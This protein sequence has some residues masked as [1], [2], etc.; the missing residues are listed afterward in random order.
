MKLKAVII[1][2][3]GLCSTLNAQS[4]KEN[5]LNSIITSFANSIKKDIEEDNT[6]GSISIAIV[7]G[8]SIIWSGAYGYADYNNNLKAD[9]ASI[10]RTGSISKSFTAF[11]MMQL[12]EDGTIKL[13]DPIEK[14]LP[15]ISELNGYSDATKITFKHL[16]SH[17]SGLI[18]EPKLKNAASGTIEEWESKVLQSIPKTSFKYKLREQYSYSNIG[19]AILGLA[20]SRAAKKSFITLVKEKIFNP[21]HMTNSFFIVPK[22]RITHLAKGMDTSSAGKNNSKAELEHKG[23]GYKVPNGGIYATPNDLAKFAAANMGYTTLLSKHSLDTMQSKHTPEENYG[24]G[25]FLYQDSNVSTVGHGG[26]VAGYTCCLFF[27]KESQYG[28]I[29]MRNYN[30]GNTKLISASK[31]LIRKLKSPSKN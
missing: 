14:Y 16:A 4:K 23:R 22:D 19:Y 13:D 11:L 31:E 1:T 25:F 29:L 30:N 12:V 28:V 3:I 24:L 8:N 5:N 9:S 7:K 18:R 15:E 10:Y 20:I 6:K 27:D 17:T 2:L 26:G 21:L